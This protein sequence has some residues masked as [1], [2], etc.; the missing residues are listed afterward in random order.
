MISAFLPALRVAVP[1]AAKQAG[2][3]TA[4]KAVGSTFRVSDDLEAPKA[5]R[6]RTMKRE[7]SM[8]ALTGAASLAIQVTVSTVLTKNKTLMKQLFKTENLKAVQTGMTAVSYAVS[9]A[10][11]RAIAPKAKWDN[12]AQSGAKLN[13]LPGQQVVY[14]KKL[15]PDGELHKIGLNET[16]NNAKTPAVSPIKLEQQG[17]SSKASVLTPV[18][19]SN[20]P[21]GVSLG[22]NQFGAM[23]ATQR[24]SYYA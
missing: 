7:A 8:L 6:N 18:Q 16:S 9:E 23:P 5:V 17:F 11:S 10:A 3:G 4:L 22:Y 12:K 14:L 19:F 1:G 20:R 24:F 15:V 13:D 2:I 21:T